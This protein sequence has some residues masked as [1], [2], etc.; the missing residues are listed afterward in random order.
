MARP[1]IAIVG[2]ADPH[3]VD[4]DPPLQHSQ[5]IPDAAEQ[6]GKE[7]AAASCRMVVYSSNPT[8]IEASVVR[9]YVQSGKAGAQ[10]IEVRYPQKNDDG[11][12]PFPEETEKPD[13][14]DFRL[15]PNPNWEVSFY[16]SLHD[17]DGIVLLGGARSAFVTG[18]LAQIFGIPLVT[19]ATFGGSAQAVWALAGNR[20]ASEEERNLMARRSWHTDSA[21]KLVKSLADQAKRRSEQIAQA[22]R[23]QQKKR[24]EDQKRAIIAG[25]LFLGAVGLMAAGMFL[26]RSQALTFGATFFLIPLLSGATGALVRTILNQREQP[27]ISREDDST[28]ISMVLG[29]IAG[30]A[31]ALLFALAQ[32]ASNPPSRDFTKGVPEGLSNLLPFLL[33]IG[34]TGG[35]TLEL[36]YRKLQET[37]IS[38]TR[39]I[40]T[41]GMT[42]V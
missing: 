39:P 20:L 16:T 42:D 31:S 37:K 41:S 3:R 33:I 19:I 6:L 25:G 36:V 24:G 1:L 26:P 2:S 22:A 28:V 32:W 11:N 15:D 30:L 38:S 35:L 14:F 18:V 23:E 29:M 17:V 10:S 5:V 21:A 8:F 13:V 40:E 7:L 9:G 4:Y 27:S 34:L 12:L